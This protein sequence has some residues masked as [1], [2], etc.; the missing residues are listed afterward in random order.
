MKGKRLSPSYLS[1]CL[2]V[3]GQSELETRRRFLLFLELLE[4]HV[5]LFTHHQSSVFQAAYYC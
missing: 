3:L 4:N 2:A 1:R 5:Q